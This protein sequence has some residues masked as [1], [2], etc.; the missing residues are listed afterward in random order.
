MR[1]LVEQLRTHHAA[2]S[3]LVAG[4]ERW[5]AKPLSGHLAGLTVGPMS[6]EVSACHARCSLGVQDAVLCLTPRTR[7]PCRTKKTLLQTLPHACCGVSC[8]TAGRGLPGAGA[9]RVGSLRRRATPHER[10]ASRH[11]PRVQH[12]RLDAHAHQHAGRFM[13]V[14][15]SVGCMVDANTSGACCARSASC[16]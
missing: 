2:L 9:G 8:R 4:E 12:A 16:E 6:K 15:V 11:G 7:T 5:A 14:Q 3:E 13:T 10:R 1:A